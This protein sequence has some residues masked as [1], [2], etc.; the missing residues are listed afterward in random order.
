MEELGRKEAKTSRRQ[1]RSER[2]G[3]ERNEREGGRIGERGKERD[4]EDRTDTE[5]I[6]EV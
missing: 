5:R 3:K 6:G 2:V 1:L 4:R